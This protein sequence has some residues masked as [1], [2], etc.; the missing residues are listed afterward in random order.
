LV[1][2]LTSEIFGWWFHNSGGSTTDGLEHV[3]ARV[4]LLKIGRATGGF[5]FTASGGIIM[6]SD[7]DEGRMSTVG[8][9]PLSQLNAGHAIKLDIQDETVE[10]RL[11]CIREKCLS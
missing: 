6:R 1:A 10:P 2:L 3:S 9:K 7:E 8:L 11:L 5:G 4:G